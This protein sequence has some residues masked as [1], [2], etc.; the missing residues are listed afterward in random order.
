MKFPFQTQNCIFP[1]LE[2]RLVRS[3]WSQWVAFPFIVVLGLELRY[4]SSSRMPLVSHCPVTWPQRAAAVVEK[5]V[6]GL[7]KR[8]YRIWRGFVLILRSAAL[9]LGDRNVSRSR[10]PGKKSIGD[11]SSATC[12][13]RHLSTHKLPLSGSIWNFLANSSYADSHQSACRLWSIQPGAE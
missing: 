4:S 8:P 2:Q 9:S 10:A 5:G 13:T 7:L 6:S 12:L 1:V 3:R 11:R